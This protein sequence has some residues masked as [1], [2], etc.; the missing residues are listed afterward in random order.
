MTGMEILQVL[1]RVLPLLAL[2]FFAGV[3]YAK[4]KNIEKMVTTILR[5]EATCKKER[6]AAEAGIHTRMTET[7]DNLHGRITET[8]KEL[9]HLKGR[10][11][12]R[13]R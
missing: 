9:A 1:S 3:F 7:A 12:G 11:N 5:S 2:V 8:A 4:L 6:E 13:G 10:L